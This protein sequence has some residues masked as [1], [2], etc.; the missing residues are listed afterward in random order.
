[1]TAFEEA[2]MQNVFGIITIAAFAT[3]LT[4]IVIMGV[5]AIVD[6]KKNRR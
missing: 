4:A 2:N 6:S 1:M 5:A 3:A